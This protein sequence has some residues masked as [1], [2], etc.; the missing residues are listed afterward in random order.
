[1]AEKPMAKERKWR[2]SSDSTC[3]KPNTGR[4]SAVNT[5][6]P[7]HPRPRLASVMPNCAALKKASR[8]CKM[9]SATFARRSPRFI[10]GL[11]CVSRT[12]T[13][14]NSAA[15]K[16]PF[17]STSATTASNRSRI[18]RTA[19]QSILQAHLSKDDLQ[20]VLK[21]QNA[22]LAAVSAQYDRQP[23]TATLHSAQG[24]FQAQAFLQV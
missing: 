19:C 13:R 20:H 5:G 10:S 7:I 16:N 6:S 1:M 8:C 18:D 12:F 9:K 15:T 24:D 11:N 14:A 21:A 4:R 22:D 17:S 2:T 3:N 23:L